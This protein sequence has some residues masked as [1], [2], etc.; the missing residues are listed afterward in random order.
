MSRRASLRI[1]SRRRRHRCLLARGCS[2]AG[3][4]DCQ[5]AVRNEGMSMRESPVHGVGVGM[6]SS[7]RAAGIEM[8]GLILDRAT[9][10]AI[11]ES[12]SRQL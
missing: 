6:D 4:A 8:P 10:A 3:I 7:L 12:R 2:I 5:P 11:V 1:T 9:S